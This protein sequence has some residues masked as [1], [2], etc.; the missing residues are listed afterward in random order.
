MEKTKA[1]ELNTNVVGFFSGTYGTVW[2]VRDTDEEG[3]ELDV[4]YNFQEMLKSIVSAYE[5]ETPQILRDLKLEAPFITGI[6]FDGTFQSPR[7]YNFSTDTLDFTVTIDNALLTATL[8]RLESDP[9]FSAYLEERFSS[10]DGFISFT[11]NNYFDLSEQIAS[12]G[13][14]F[15]QSLGAL[16]SYLVGDDGL[17]DIEEMAYEHWSCNGFCGLDYTTSEGDV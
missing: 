1:V 9:K 15:V 2:E 3:N 8:K 11:P 5:S 10:R 7:E 14:E 6:S 13:G 16:I 17:R 12:E 4:E